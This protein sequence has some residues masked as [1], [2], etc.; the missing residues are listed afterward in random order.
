[1]TALREIDAL[2]TAAMSMREQHGPQ[3]ERHAMWTAIADLM[4]A[5]ADRL[6]ASGGARSPVDMQILG[7]A[8]AYHDATGGVA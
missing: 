8:T 7:V 3:H 5:A 2:R 6:T 4:D 1:M